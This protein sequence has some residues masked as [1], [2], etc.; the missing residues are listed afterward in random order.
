MKAKVLKNSEKI[1]F[2][3]I[4]GAQNQEKLKSISMKI[5]LNIVLW[6]I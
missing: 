4:K 1:Y 5:I 2:S 6:I 3:T